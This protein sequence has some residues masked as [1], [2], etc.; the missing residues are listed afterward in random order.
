[1]TATHTCHCMTEDPGDGLGERVVTHSSSC[2]DHPDPAPV[3]KKLPA[4]TP[5][6]REVFDRVAGR[7]QRM[8]CGSNEKNVRSR[9]AIDHLIHKGYLQVE[10]TLIGPRG[11]RT[12]IIEPTPAGADFYRRQQERL[13]AKLEANQPL[14]DAVLATRAAWDKLP[15]AERLAA[16]NDA[17]EALAKVLR[18]DVVRAEKLAHGMAR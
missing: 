13:Q 16:H 10:R 18:V 11:G 8:G 6:Q 17:V 3:E 7:A 14:V 9:T 1:M 15:C 12:R 5:H 2:A 4:L